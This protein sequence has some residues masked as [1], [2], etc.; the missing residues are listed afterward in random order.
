MLVRHLRNKLG[1]TVNLV[2]KLARYSLRVG[3]L[4]FVAFKDEL[5]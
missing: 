3:L 5:S 1:R 4:V 2:K